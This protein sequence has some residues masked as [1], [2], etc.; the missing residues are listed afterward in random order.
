MIIVILFVIGMVITLI[1]DEN[2]FSPT[3]MLYRVISSICIGIPVT[4][5][6]IVF[7]QRLYEYHLG[8]FIAFIVA[9]IFGIVLMIYLGIFNLSTTMCEHLTTKSNTEELSPW[10]HRQKTWACTVKDKFET[11]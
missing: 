11:S 7:G 9:F 8:M 4:Y 3:Q 5:F 2:D 1:I 6:A 10:E